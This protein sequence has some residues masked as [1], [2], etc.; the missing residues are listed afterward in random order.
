MDNRKEIVACKSQTE[1]QEQQAFG[2]INNRRN[3]IFIFKH[4]YCVVNQ[5]TF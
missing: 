4:F 1:E 2:A 5:K 3:V